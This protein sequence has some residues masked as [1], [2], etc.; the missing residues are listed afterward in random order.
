MEMARKRV[1]VGTSDSFWLPGFA[2]VP[3]APCE[4]GICNGKGLWALATSSTATSRTPT[5][6][7]DA[8]A[9]MGNVEM[10]EEGMW[11]EM[12]G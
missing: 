3:T 10:Q 2:E 7:M 1:I 6:T 8:N 9:A 4:E 11:R 12:E 5:I